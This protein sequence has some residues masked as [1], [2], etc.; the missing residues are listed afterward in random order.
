MAFSPIELVDL[1]LG[2]ESQDIAVYLFFLWLY[3]LWSF[4]QFWSRFLKFDGGVSHY[5]MCQPQFS[6]SYALL[7]TY[8]MWPALSDVHKEASIKRGTFDGLRR[9]FNTSVHPRNHYVIS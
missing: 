4:K 7:Y 5:E 6:G 9:R 2:Y 1:A 3:D 8:G